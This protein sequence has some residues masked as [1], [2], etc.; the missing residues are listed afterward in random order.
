VAEIANPGGWLESAVKQFRVNVALDQTTDLRPGFSCDA[1]IL[2]DTLPKVLIAPI[3][4]VF[5]DGGEY[6]AYVQSALGPV[7]TPVKVGKSSVTHVEILSGLKKGQKVYLSK[8]SMKSRDDV[9][10]KTP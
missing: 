8:P 3:Q 2:I 6:V 9:E 4:S 1:E 7:R 10:A 5:S